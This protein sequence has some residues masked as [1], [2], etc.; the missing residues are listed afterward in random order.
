MN[1]FLVLDF[2]LRVG[3]I[4]GIIGVEYVKIMR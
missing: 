4:M 1:I 2:S 3:I